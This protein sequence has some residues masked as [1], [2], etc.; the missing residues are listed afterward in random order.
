ML[1]TVCRKGFNSAMFQQEGNGSI[2]WRKLARVVPISPEKNRSRAIPYSLR[3]THP[4]QRQ[5]ESR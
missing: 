5:S 2:Y 3:G 1:T 4:G